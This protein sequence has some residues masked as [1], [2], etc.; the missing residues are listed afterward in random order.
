MKLRVEVFLLFCLAAIPAALF[1]QAPAG[2]EASAPRISLAE[3]KKLQATNSVVVIDVRAQSSYEEG[4]IP[5]AI[6]MPLE[7]LAS[8]VADLKRFDKP[9]VA[10]CS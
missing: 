10:Y 2:D 3:L 8:R 6:S 5:G 4:H 7:T 1:A 9:V